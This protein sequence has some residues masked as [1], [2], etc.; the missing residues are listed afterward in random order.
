MLATV[1]SLGN[2]VASATAGLLW[3]LVSPTAAFVYAAT[4][5]VLALIAFTAIRHAHT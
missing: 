1:Q 4:W 5:M 2:F 3:T